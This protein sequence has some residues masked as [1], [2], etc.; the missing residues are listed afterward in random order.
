MNRAMRLY[1]FRISHFSEKVR[2]SLDLAGI[3]YEE[4]ALL[5]GAHLAWTRRLA[6]RTNVPILVMGDEVV[7]GSGAI[8]DR[9]ESDARFAPFAVAPEHRE[10]AMELEA[11]ADHAFGRGTQCIFYDALFESPD[12]VV[13]LWT[14]RGP[15][16]GRAFYAVML[17][18]IRPTMRK[19]YRIDSKGVA[20]AT[21]A[22]HR[23]FDEMDRMTESK[24]FLFGDAIT[25]ADIAV[26][27]LL[28]PLC[29]PKE[30][31]LEWPEPAGKLAQFI[32]PFEGR[33]TWEWVR[34]LY[35]D[36]RRATR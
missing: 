21:D 9:L 5:P 33:P 22:F 25:R 3:P 31:P 14:Q 36:H 2:W 16:W 18:F 24:P 12:R 34:R 7:Q 19:K 23:A 13:S 8:L 6:K 27:A 15:F 10:R 26:A 11:L 35:R 30:H 4:K 1:T 28:A 20:E 17:P 29:R 32:T